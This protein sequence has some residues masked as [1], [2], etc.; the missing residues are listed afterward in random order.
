MPVGRFVLDVHGEDRTAWPWSD[1]LCAALQIVNHLQDCG[2]D[3]RALG[4][5]YLP[6][7]LMAA[8]GA[9]VRDL[10]ADA[11]TPAL[12]RVIEALARRT[13]GLL[14]ES[15]GFAGRIADRRLALEV[16]VIQRL[17]E[18]LADRLAVRDPLSERV[19]HRTSEALLLSARAMAAQFARRRA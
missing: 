12:R 2:K 5:C 19:H 3:W 15:A 14:R 13:R 9:D 17:A 4:R 6:L 16:A 11:A 8:E 18:D 10:G 7:D 1:A